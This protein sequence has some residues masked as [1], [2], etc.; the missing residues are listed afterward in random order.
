MFFAFSFSCA[1]ICCGDPWSASLFLS[2]IAIYAK[3]K[4]TTI[5]YFCS[6]LSPSVGRRLSFVC[7]VLAALPYA[8]CALPAHIERR[9]IY[10]YSYR[11]HNITQSAIYCFNA[12]MQ[13][14]VQRFAAFAHAFL[15]Y[16][17]NWRGPN[18]LRIPHHSTRKNHA[19]RMHWLNRRR[20]EKRILCVRFN[21]YA[22]AINRLSICV[23]WPSPTRLIFP[24]DIAQSQ[25]YDT[26][27]FFS[28]IADTIWI[29]RWQWTLRCCK[30]SSS[31]HVRRT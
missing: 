31:R 29:S 30:V 15:R 5:V 10:S 12:R 8:R 23:H 9:I 28:V 1:S 14:A 17:S 11:V 7:V 4:C 18:G 3:C 20:E 26:I 24:F 22:S 2:Q 6:A 21:I 13:H 19:A 25:F 27:P 16:K